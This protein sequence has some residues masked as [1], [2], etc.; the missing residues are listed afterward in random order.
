MKIF[1]I[2]FIKFSSPV[3]LLLLLGEFY[4]LYFPSTFNQKA[5]YLHTH[6]AIV[7]TAI[8]GSSH[9]Q[10]ALNPE[11]LTMP[12]INLANAGQDV[13]LDSALFFHTLPKLKALRTVVLELD[14]HTLEEKNDEDYFRLPWYYRFFGVELYPVSMLNKVSVYAS[15]PAFFNQL[16]IDHLNPKKIT[17]HLNQYGFITNDF[18][19]VMEDLHYDTAALNSTA[20][21]RLK[22]K[23]HKDCLLYTSRCV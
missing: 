20:A 12:A 16:F 7:Q 9:N 17:Y 1:L 23:H 15:S 8:F 14:Y 10:N 22:D 18:P 21:H 5:A 2:K 3:I 4:V 6:A 19:G 11:Y 13:Q